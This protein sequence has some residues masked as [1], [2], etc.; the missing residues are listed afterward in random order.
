MGNNEIHI[1]LA[2]SFNRVSVYNSGSL[3]G[4]RPDKYFIA[5]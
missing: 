4:G 2:D 5:I 3:E 1:V